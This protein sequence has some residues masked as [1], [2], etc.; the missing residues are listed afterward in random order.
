MIF[1]KIESGIS[2]EGNPIEVYKTDIKANKYIYI[3]AGVHG[4]EVEGVYVMKELFDWLKTDHSL[5]DLPLIVLPIVN[6]DGYARGTRINANQV[7]LNR[8]MPTE[9][10]TSEARAPRYN[11]GPSPLSEPENKFLVKLFDKYKPG[12]VLSFHTWKPML[13]YNGTCEDVADYLYSFNGYEKASDIGYPT[14]G[15]H[16]DFIWSKYQSPVL[17]FECPELK[18]HKQTLKEIWE[19]NEKGLKGLFSENRLERFIK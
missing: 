10:W 18:I 16:G 11:P 1:S 13:N 7:D 6:P 8:N 3:L 15:S 5:K 9:N 12:F 4:D 14:P 2:V 19:E 17:T